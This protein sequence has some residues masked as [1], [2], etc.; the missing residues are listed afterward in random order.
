LEVRREQRSLDPGEGLFG[1]SGFS[2]SSKSDD[3]AEDDRLLDWMKL[4]SDPA[5]S[6]EVDLVIFRI[7]SIVLTAEMFFETMSLRLSISFCSC[8]LMYDRSKLD[9]LLPSA[10]P[11]P[12]RQSL[13][14][15]P[16]NV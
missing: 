16:S 11:L 4:C 15:T 7:L 5:I 8:S 3:T 6:N 13:L 1:K 10:S 2:S 12:A 14:A 9:L